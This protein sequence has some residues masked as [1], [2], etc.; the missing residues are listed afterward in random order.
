MMN[1]TGKIKITVFAVLIV[2]MSFCLHS[3]NKTVFA[4][5][6]V[7]QNNI[8]LRWVPSDKTVL[9]LAVKNGYKITRYTK[10]NNSLSSPLVIAEDLKPYSKQDTLKWA[11]L[12]QS[13]DGGV[14]AYK[15]LN[16][17]RPAGPSTPTQIQNEKMYY[18]LLLLSCD[19]NSEVAKA[20][21]LFIKDSSISNNKLYSYKIEINN[22]PAAF[23]FVPVIIDVNASKLSADPVIKGL[24]GTF[25]NKDV[26]LRWKSV[27]YKNDY[28]AY[29]VERSSDSINYKKINP[30]PVI[31][32]SSQFEKKK[33]FITYYDTFPKLKIRYY[34]RIRGINHFGEQGE[35]SNIVS[36][37][38]YEPLSSFPII[39][40]IKT[41]A[42]QKVF[43][44][45]R[46]QDKKENS[47]PK[48]YFLV[49]S[50]KDKG[51]YEKIFSS[52]NP[53]S[54]IDEKP[55]S[56]NYYKAGVI[57][58]GGDTL[59]SYSYLALIADTIPPVPPT[60][61]KAKV[62]VKGNVTLTWDKN[63]EQD[64]QG[65][66]IL[67]SNALHE[68]FVQ[69]NNEFARE[70]IYKDK[71]NLKTLTKHIYYSVVATDK[72]YNNSNKCTPIEVKRPDTIA[73]VKPILTN[74]SL[75][76]NGVN[77][78]WINSNSEDVK[79]YVLYR[80]I[81]Q[82]TK[83]IK[84]KEWPAKDSLKQFLDTTVEMG[85]GYRYRLLVSDED[86]NFSV[87]NNPYIKFETGYRKKMTGITFEVDR[88]NKFIKLKW[89]YDQKDIEKFVLY[90][91]KKGSQ[92]TIIK[93]LPGK[94]VEF[95]DSTPN[96]GNIYEYRV[97]PVF[98]NGAEGIIS[99]AILIEY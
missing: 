18:G 25:R 47:L 27:D 19:L 35:P 56:A 45:F 33:D 17:D 5:H 4:K 49:R 53:S 20:T 8:L 7:K 87:S 9:D 71:L 72:R 11:R 52:K 83:E 66:K 12:I 57:S 99:E 6:Y 51:P 91:A 85:V 10:E 77:V 32:L 60:G 42:N 65:Y 93:T 28:S 88:L 38:G 95:V 74:L 41:V 3:Q 69:I 61:L 2:L 16:N 23:K 14:I 36:G 55:E 26:K 70:P 76:N 39:D 22:P 86:D 30:S 79:Y 59:Y 48:E 21:G 78:N 80:S 81:E 94:I 75:K 84:V 58:Y 40:S 89:S 24:S 1:N 82:Q 13:T 67:K 64:V 96:M 50:K 15:V 29:N 92:L 73:P 37:T 68:E 31:L 43:I 34:Y 54:Y 63:P 46:M 44:Q 62:D 97:K 98:V 90:R